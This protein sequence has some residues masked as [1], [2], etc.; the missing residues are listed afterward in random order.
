MLVDFI[1]ILS[2]Q[3]KILM[4]Y[5]H[6]QN[7]TY[8]SAYFHYNISKIALTFYVVKSNMYNAIQIL[9]IIML[10]VVPKIIKT[11]LTILTILTNN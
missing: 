7:G 9:S 8:S 4:T 5:S 6:S 1:N 3:E 11:I 10:K 2:V